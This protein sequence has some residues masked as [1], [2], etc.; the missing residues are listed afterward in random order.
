L[1]CSSIGR[2][3]ILSPCGKGTSAFSKRESN[4]AIKYIP[5]LV[6]AILE[7]SIL[8]KEI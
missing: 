1:I 7:V 5:A 8:S 3:Q 4:P 2:F 6:L